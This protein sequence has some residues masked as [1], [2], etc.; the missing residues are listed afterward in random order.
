MDP[1]NRRE[2]V[3]QSAFGVLARPCDLRGRGHAPEVDLG[4]DQYVSAYYL[5]RRGNDEGKDNNGTVIPD[6]W[7]HSRLTTHGG[8]T[9]SP[10]VVTRPP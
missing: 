6:R 7:H 2:P 5:S 10:S 9:T 4:G 1:L 3:A 8:G